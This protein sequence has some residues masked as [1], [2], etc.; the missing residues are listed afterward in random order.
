MNKINKQNKQNKKNK[1]NKQK[2][3]TATKKQTQKRIEK[4]WQ[5]NIQS[6]WGSAVVHFFGHIKDS[7]LTENMRAFISY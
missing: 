2:K 6:N 3:A 1:Q 7:A 4:E 5:E